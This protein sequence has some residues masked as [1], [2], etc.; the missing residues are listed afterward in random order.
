MV[1]DLEG[2]AKNVKINGR[3]YAARTIRNRIK[4]NTLP[5]YIK[6]YKFKCG[7][8][9]E[10]A[11]EEIPEHIRKNFTVLLRPKIKRKLSSR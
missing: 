2:L 3:F 7:Y 1:Y 11:P 9:F 5:S 6:V 4:N 8:V 10:I